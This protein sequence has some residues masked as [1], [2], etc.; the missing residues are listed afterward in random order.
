[1]LADGIFETAGRVDDVEHSLRIKRDMSEMP[2]AAQM[3]VQQAAIHD[4]G[5]AHASAKRQKEHIE[6]AARGAEPAFSQQGGF[7]VVEDRY[8]HFESEPLLP[9]QTFETGELSG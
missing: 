3:S 4:G 7:G 9:I 6:R 1:M 2:G 5:A 8:R